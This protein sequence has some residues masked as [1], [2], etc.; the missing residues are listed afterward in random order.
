VFCA[1]C[2]KQEKLRSVPPPYQKTALLLQMRR[3]IGS[4]HDRCRRLLEYAHGTQWF[5]EGRRRFRGWRQWHHRVP[6]RAISEA[7]PLAELGVSQKLSLAGTPQ[8]RPPGRRRKR[9][10]T[11]TY[12]QPE[13]TA[14][15]MCIN[16]WQVCP[17]QQSTLATWDIDSE[18]GSEG[19]SSGSTPNFFK[20][21]C[22]IALSPRDST[23]TLFSPGLCGRG[24]KRL[25]W[26]IQ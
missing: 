23:R 1:T 18:T 9:P 4:N 24:W 11:I 22:L 16:L 12:R 26:S 25:P 14:R 20:C 2:C 17:C 15:T 21:R 5:E 19:A 7:E 3:A 6:A 8:N 10:L 13:A